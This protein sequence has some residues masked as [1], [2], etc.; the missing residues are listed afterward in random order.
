[1]LAISSLTAGLIGIGLYLALLGLLGLMAHKARRK[2]KKELADQATV[3][4]DWFDE[5]AYHN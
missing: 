5:Y 2:A 1:M 4:M 3:K